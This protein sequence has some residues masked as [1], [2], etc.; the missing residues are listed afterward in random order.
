MRTKTI[1]LEHRPELAAHDA[2]GHVRAEVLLELSGGAGFNAAYELLAE[3][4]GPRG[5]VEDL[6]AL[7]RLVD[8]PWT[9]G[10]IQC[11]YDV[12]LA[13]DAKGAL[14][15]AGDFFITVDAAQ[16]FVLG[17]W[18]NMHVAPAAR[19]RGIGSMLDDELGVRVRDIAA[20]AGLAQNATLLIASDLSPIDIDDLDTWRRM[21]LWSRRGYRLL[22]Y[23]AFPLAHL[24]LVDPSGSAHH[25][26]PQP[27]L[28]VV[29][30]ADEPRALA[31]LPR[32]ALYGLVGSL[33]AIDGALIRDDSWM[34][35]AARIRR[36]IDAFPHD[37]V[38][39]LPLPGEARTLAELSPLLRGAA[40][41]GAA[42]HED[43][44]R[45]LA[46]QCRQRGWTC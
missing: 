17:V 26:P 42:P 28:T 38:A 1:T 9:H 14:L 27:A 25:L 15:G 6:S 37:E 2:H 16:R 43:E 40:F 11:R 3:Y 44:L 31:V 8:A 19:G 20:A 46:A 34:D 22:P 12:M 23:A 10:E 33:V 24:E 7:R 5:E 35:N 13:R 18:N 21:L 30:R 36:A 39:L 45:W 29:R 4:F 32:D 41:T